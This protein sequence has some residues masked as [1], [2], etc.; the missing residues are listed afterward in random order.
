MLWKVILDNPGQYI[1][2]FNSPLDALQKLQD[3]DYA[4]D[5]IFQQQWER[6]VNWIK[7]GGVVLTPNS[8]YL[9]PN[10]GSPA[11][12]GRLM[13][14]YFRVLDIASEQITT[15][16]EIAGDDGDPLDRLQQLLDAEDFWRG[17]SGVS[18]FI[19]LKCRSLDLI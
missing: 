4:F 15:T 9:G 1:G 2:S 17:S 18:R 13:F 8:G 12:H 16:E 11:I 7:E 10:N 14:P 6:A 5:P 19:S 3:E